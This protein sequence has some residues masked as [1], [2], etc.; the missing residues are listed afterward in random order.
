MAGMTTP[1][2]VEPVKKVYDD[3]TCTRIPMGKLT[4]ALDPLRGTGMIERVK[5]ALT[6]GDYS[7]ASTLVSAESASKKDKRDYL[8][9][10]PA[11]AEAIK[12]I[13]DKLDQP[14]VKAVKL[15]KKA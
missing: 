14:V 7:L 4:T 6:N 15:V 8:L 3:T 1:A 12:A 10:V 9:V 11:K 13:V 5:I 2:V